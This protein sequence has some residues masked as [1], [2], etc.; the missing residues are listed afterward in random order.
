MG[1]EAAAD[2]GEEAVRGSFR[3][4]VGAAAGEVE[5]AVVGVEADLAAAVGPAEEVAPAA[6]GNPMRWLFASPAP[7][8]H[9][10]VVEAIQAAEAGTSG[11]IRVVVARHGT[12]DPLASAQRHFQRLKMEDTADRN[13][14]LIFIAPRSRK[15]A[16]V[17]DKGIHER[18]GD[19]HWNAVVDGL[20]EHF[21]NGDF[22]SGLVEAVAAIGKEL[23]AHFPKE[24]ARKNQLPDD[25]EE[26][27]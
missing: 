10:K 15:F 20:T 22:T 9:A 17:G 12:A 4:V 23:A 13:G 6:A 26:V 2:S 1:G 14:V 7:I 3:A 19:S 27:D 18:V 21:V 5:E 16:V 25:V 8:D 24:G 11:E